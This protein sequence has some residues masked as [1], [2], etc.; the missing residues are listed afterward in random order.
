MPQY[1][2]RNST[3]R[4]QQP[5]S[6]ATM[7]NSP[8]TEATPKSGST[9]TTTNAPE[10]MKLAG[11]SVTLSKP[12]S[13]P[14][15]VTFL[16]PGFT[17][18]VNE[19][20][21]LREVLVEEQHQVVI[22]F[23]IGFGKS[24]R[25]YASDVA[26]IFV[27]Y[28]DKFPGTVTTNK[29]NIVAHSV[30]AKIAL[31]VVAVADPTKVETVIALDPVDE[32]PVEFTM[33][34]NPTLSLRDTSAKVHITWANA[35]VPRLPGTGINPQHNAQSIHAISREWIA[36]LVIHADAT[37]FAYTD[38]GGGAPGWVYVGGTKEGNAAA[39][40]DVQAM[41]RNLIK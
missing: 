9:P 34:E 31:L 40:A 25:Q 33:G 21:S 19:Y 3:N 29:Y 12:T 8:S 4:A 27:A 32:R 39:K 6:S 35:T 7:G 17:V 18:S 26:A 13:S 30:G 38:K 36:P 10:N 24:H 22:S 15:G 37:H 14:R 16:L 23:S 1:Q 2:Q 20:N 5:S 41:I 11:I 28:C